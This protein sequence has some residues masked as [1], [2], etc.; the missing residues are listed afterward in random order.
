MQ[1]E[2]KSQPTASAKKGGVLSKLIRKLNL[3]DY[4]KSPFLLR[5]YFATPIMSMVFYRLG[6]GHSPEEEFDKYQPYLDLPIERREEIIKDMTREFY[7]H[8][9]C[10]DE[11]LYYD[12]HHHPEREYRR[13]FVTGPYK[14][15]TIGRVNK[16]RSML[17]FNDKFAFAEYYKRYFRRKFLLIRSQ[18]DFPAFCAF[19]QQHP[20]FI[21]KPIT[22]AKGKGVEVIDSADYPDARTLFDEMLAED[23]MLLEELVNQDPAMQVLNESS[24]NTIRM[25]T[26]ITG[27]SP[28]TYEVHIFHPCVRIGRAGSV[29]DNAERGGILVKIDD[30]ETGRLYPIGKDRHAVPYTN[31][32]E[33]GLCFADFCIPQWQELLAISKEVALKTPENRFVGWD[34]ALSAENGW[35]LIEGNA[36]LNFSGPQICDLIGKKPE[37]KALLAKK[38]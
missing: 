7:F 24:V 9:V 25:I 23:N 22:G 12:F 5:F 1:K 6:R 17:L 34:Y 10:F 31:H 13:S 38:K 26:V 19:L 28:E 2:E 14:D 30:L 8:G 29:I 33:N 20:K 35:V 27:N 11:Y 37:L 36:A 18:A 3:K 16:I 32:P 4:K 21:K 15:V